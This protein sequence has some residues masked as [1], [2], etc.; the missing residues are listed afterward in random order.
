MAKKF[1]Q[2]LGSKPG[3]VVELIN[4]EKS[5]FKVRTEDGFE[6]WL[7]SEDFK[8]YYKELGAPSPD[9]WKLFVTDESGAMVETPVAREA[10]DIINSLKVAFQD[11]TKARHF[12]K[13]VYKELSVETKADIHAIR[14]LL[15]KSAKFPEAIS[16]KNIHD[17]IQLSSLAKDLLKGD[18][19]AVLDWPLNH[20]VEIGPRDETSRKIL[21]E[22]TPKAV[23]NAPQKMKNVEFSVQGETLTI[24]V[25][26]SK[27]F[28]PS[29]SGKTII[30]ASTEGNKTVPGRNEKV[31]LNVYKELGTAKKSGNKE[32]FKNINMR[33]SDDS[34]AITVDL[35][36][37][38]GPSKSGKTIIIGSTGGNQLV[39]GRPEKIGLNVY[40]PI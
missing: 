12:L 6:F 20:S 10:V 27:E 28:G 29:K 24:R 30:V 9:K 22:V 4:G 19:F 26:L 31:G 39:Y 23:R 40:K 36:Q 8:N 25:D 15:R 34:L 16:D 38:L 2:F 21:D 1:L 5:P 17:I 37:E 14:E 11:F 35:S 3:N 32:S 33:V 13:G 7:S 18:V